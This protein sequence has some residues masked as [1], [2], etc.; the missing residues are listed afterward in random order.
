MRVLERMEEVR[1]RARF[2]EDGALYR[3][4]IGMIWS[5]A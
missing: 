1:N 3:H 5:F 2:M 4:F